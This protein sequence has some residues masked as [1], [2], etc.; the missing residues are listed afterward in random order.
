[1]YSIP[2]FRT[3]SVT[4][5]HVTDVDRYDTTVSY[6]AVHDS[7]VLHTLTEHAQAVSLPSGVNLLIITD[8]ITRHTLT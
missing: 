5:I 8:L 7:T 4:C 2:Q 1:M 6:L 3:S